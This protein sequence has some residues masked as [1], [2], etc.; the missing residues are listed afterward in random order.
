MIKLPFSRKSKH[1]DADKPSVAFSD[2]CREELERRRDCG[3][4][5]DEERFQAAV[6]L[7]IGRL[8]GM[9][10]EGKE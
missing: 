7:A 8:Q 1:E 4:D 5:F 6:D 3:G 9:E 10:E 2:Y